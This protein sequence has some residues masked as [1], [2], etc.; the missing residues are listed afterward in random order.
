MCAWPCVHHCHLGLTLGLDTSHMTLSVAFMTI[1][2]KKNRKEDFEYECLHLIQCHVK[3][4]TDLSDFNILK[5]R[6][7]EKCIYFKHLQVN[8]V[9]IV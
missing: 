7:V 6:I 4:D 1:A 9:I 3:C 5:L 2:V 8:F